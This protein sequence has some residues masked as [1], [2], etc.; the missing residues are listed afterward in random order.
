[1]AGNR[2]QFFIRL[3]AAVS[4]GT[5][6]IFGRP[7]TILVPARLSN[8]DVPGITTV[9]AAAFKKLEL[10]VLHVDRENPAVDRF[11][12]YL[13]MAADGYR[14]VGLHG[15]VSYTYSR[16]EFEESQRDR[17]RWAAGVFTIRER[18]LKCHQANKQTT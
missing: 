1:M 8:S 12:E 6:A 10:P 4:T 7:R 9:D 5:A 18:A 14:C 17:S 3:I 2:R 11:M 15:K 13:R 16:V